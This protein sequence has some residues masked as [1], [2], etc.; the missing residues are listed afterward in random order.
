M[1]VSSGYVNNYFEDP[2]CSGLHL[3]GNDYSPLEEDPDEDDELLNDSKRSDSDD[4]HGLGLKE[5]S[6]PLSISAYNSL[7]WPS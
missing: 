6:D 5:N 2:G 4:Q 3:N 1:Y 7:M